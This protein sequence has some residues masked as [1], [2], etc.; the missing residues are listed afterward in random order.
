MLKKIT[1]LIKS[2]TL[3]I[4]T[5]S[6]IGFLSLS[7]PAFALSGHSLFNS[8]GCITCHTINGKGGSI[9]PNLSHIGSQRSLSWI[10]TQIATPGKH[11][12]SGS[13]VTINGNSYMAIMP[14]H[15]NISASKLNALAKYL[16]SLK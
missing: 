4:A 13:T 9:G 3:G 8:E 7:V 5:L 14:G 2:K 6:A 10:E 16:E 1:K 11:F 15:K 12:K